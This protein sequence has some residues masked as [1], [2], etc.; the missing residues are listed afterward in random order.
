[1]STDPTTSRWLVDLSTE[2]C[3]ELAMSRPVGRLAWSG[4]HG[5]TVIPV[6]FTA[7][8]KSV[9]IRTKAYS[10]AARECE[11]TMVAFQVDS[12]DED[13]RQGWSVL[14][15]GRAHFEYSSPSSEG[16]PDVW[17][18]GP[19]SLQLR[20]EVGEVTGRRILGSD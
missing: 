8:G 3:W 17:V 6:N 2:D 20:I 16:G 14:M 10:E 11:D 13:T 12:F 5:P 15:R 1:M 7:D 4:P 18:S 19:R 9:M